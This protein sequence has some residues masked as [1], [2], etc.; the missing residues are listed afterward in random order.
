VWSEHWYDSVWQSTGFAPYRRRE[1]DLDEYQTRLL[2]ACQPHYD[3]L[4]PLRIVV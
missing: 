2:E 3:R 1:T 4:F